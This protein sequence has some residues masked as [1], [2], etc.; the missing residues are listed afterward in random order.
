M[1]GPERV[2][3]VSCKA[4]QEGFGLVP[5]DGGGWATLP[6]DFLAKHGQHLADLRDLGT[7]WYGGLSLMPR[8]VNV[9]IGPSGSSTN[10]FAVWPI[11]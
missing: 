10:P 5:L 11:L 2:R 1:T 6:R 8:S 7:L 4:W 3:V 9:L